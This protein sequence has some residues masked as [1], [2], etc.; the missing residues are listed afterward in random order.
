MDQPFRLTR[1][2]H[3]LIARW[4]LIVLPVAVAVIVAAVLGI[5]T[6]VRYTATATLI[7]PTPQI[8]WRWENKIY[9]VVDPRFDWRGEV[10]ALFDTKKL[11]E[12]ALGKVEGQLET[13]VTAEDLRA[14]AAA[15]RG[16]G[17]LLLVRVKAASPGDAIL[18][19]DAVAQ[20]V[21]ETVADLYAGDVA[22]N[23]KALGAA[24]AEYKKWDDQLLQF[25][26]RTGIGIGGGGELAS[27]RGD[28]LYGAQSTIKHELT[29]KNSDRASLQNAIDRID[30]VLAQLETS[31]A[32][33]STALLDLPELETYG[34]DYTDLTQ[35]AKSSEAALKSR[36]E[37][38]RQQ[39]SI[40]L[41]ALAEN[42]VARQFV[43]SAST[44]EWENT[45][46]VRGVWL[47]SVTALERRA[48]ELQMKR[49]IEGDR[50]RIL[51]TATA[52]TGPSQPNWLFNIGLA[53]VA[54]LLLG[55]LLA[56]IS[57]YW[58]GAQA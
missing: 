44:Q 24:K 57:I 48:V 30:I 2:L 43:E 12:R 23:Q 52:P 37:G 6:P 31:P 41:D 9:E 53:V 13:P 35:L 50:V 34:A 20:A 49:L 32:T 29:I 16:A 45:L 26:G 14:A 15:S 38:L 18:L 17:S 7:T 51:D 11:F 1:Y 46:R 19:A 39:M 8:T 36:L 56:I 5:L 58:R 33:A 40:D 4:P 47:E 25:R 54:G 21:P 42:A 28:G 22:A 27:G 3:L 55:L 10:I